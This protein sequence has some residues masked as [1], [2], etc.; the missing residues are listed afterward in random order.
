MDRYPIDY[1]TFKETPFMGVAIE[2]ANKNPNSICQ[3]AISYIS[4]K[5]TLK[6]LVWN[7]KPPTN[8]FS[9]STPRGI[10]AETVRDALPFYNVW[11]EHIAKIMNWNILAAHYCNLTMRAI[12]DSYEQDFDSGRVFPAND[13]VVYDTY[14]A[15][16][17]ALF[18]LS[19]YTL[20]TI[21][22]HIGSDIDIS[23]TL[24][25]SMGVADLLHY[26]FV[27]NSV[28]VGY[29]K[30]M[31]YAANRH[32]FRQWVD[33]IDDDYGLQGDPCLG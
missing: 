4:E 9:L 12:I 19:D 18:G 17:S 30:I 15:S 26:L 27:K 6:G 29:P 25:R 21:L 24:N 28:L 22:S 10:T 1:Q 14:I 11:D 20:K 33:C 5:T 23:S 2:L 31:A 8:D 32:C 7:V 16:K 13:I 3:I